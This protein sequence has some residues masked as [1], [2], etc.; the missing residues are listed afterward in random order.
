[1]D[2][3]CFH[4]STDR[5]F[6]PKFE[7]LFGEPRPSK[8]QFFTES[9]RFS[10]VLRRSARKLFRAMQTEPAFR[11]YRSQH[12]ECHRGIAVGHGAQSARARPKL[13]RLCI[14]GGVALNS[15]A[16]SRILRETPF[17]ELFIQP[18]A[19]DGGGALGAAL[20]AYHTLLGKP[21]NFVMKHAYWG[22]L[23]QRR[24]SAIFC[25][26]TMSRIAI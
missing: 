10:E 2:Y 6:R 1:M 5:T 11:R 22:R 8:L 24:R 13:T 19:G 9:H 16:N 14:A 15:V 3:F 18:A 7:A 20:W 26:R 21:R 4:H 23:I 12:S 25:A 17:E